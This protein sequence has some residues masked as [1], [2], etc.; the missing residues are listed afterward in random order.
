MKSLR[1]RKGFTLIELMVAIVL[2]LLI[3]AAA[4][5][6]FISGQS[7]YRVQQA[8]A[9][10]QDG[11]IFGINAA[12]R[13]I[14]L[15]NQGNGSVINDQ[16]AYGGIVLSAQTTTG[17]EG[18]TP[19]GNLKNLKVGTTVITG[20]QYISK[21]EATES[22]NN[23]LAS[24]QLVIIYQAP[25]NMVTCT[26]K[27]VKGP[28][29][30][31]DSLAKGWYVIEKYYIKKRSTDNGADLYCSDA[32]FIAKGE[33][34]PQSYTVSSSTTTITTNETLTADYGKNSG[35]MIAQNVEYMRIQLIVRNSDNS[36]GTMAIDH[37]T[38]NLTLSSADTKRPNVIGINMGWLVRSSEQVPNNKIT[39]YQVLDKTINAPDGDKFMRN[40]YSTTIALRNG[41][42]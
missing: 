11:G 3:T 5:Q 10:I 37:Y 12:T 2:G 6:L 40:V 14:R 41:G 26:G 38:N 13:N 32:L 27:H 39:V 36:I 28:D 21:S 22:A 31:I 19:A 9:T 42:L 23:F 24:D 8:A 20:N 1:L 4:L 17:F 7:S 16:T 34:V 25:L 18:A 30:K 33:T 29:R 15:A 35:E